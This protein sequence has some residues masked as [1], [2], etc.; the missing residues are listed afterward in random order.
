[1]KRSHVH[2]SPSGSPSPEIP[3]SSLVAAPLNSLCHRLAG[4]VR[5]HGFVLCGG[6]ALGTYL[7]HRRS[8][9][10]DFFSGSKFDEERLW[11]SLRE[12]GLYPQPLKSGIDSQH[13][14]TNINGTKVEFVHWRG[15]DSVHVQS[16]NDCDLAVPELSHLATMK[17]RAAASRGMKRDIIDMYFL[18]EAGFSP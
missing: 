3:L 17:T 5:D 7:G 11:E 8:N 12:V 9:D 13:I 15:L 18:M 6:A 4:V 16:V 10:L 1:M 2:D 14:I